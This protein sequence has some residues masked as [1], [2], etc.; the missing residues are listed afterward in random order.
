MWFT[1]TPWPPILICSV[2]AV[3]LV[4]M[5]Q[6]N[7]RTG[8]VL[9][10][11]LLVIASVAIYFV[12][13]AIV[14]ESEQL[15]AAV[16]DLTDAFR[17]NDQKTMLSFFSKSAIAEQLAVIGAMKLVDVGKDLRVTDDY[18]QFK[19][20]NSRAILHFRANATIK[21]SGRD[22]GK[23]PSRWELTWQREADDWKI[24]RVQRLNPINGKPM[25]TLAHSP[26]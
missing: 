10:A 4:A 1:E 11:G 26:H 25:G 22:F 16:I 14:T 20:E 12:E 17:R 8:T 9:A 18:V 23:Q 5:W 24:I 19:A 7:R 13:Q 3:C 21:L 2:F 15:E 6:A